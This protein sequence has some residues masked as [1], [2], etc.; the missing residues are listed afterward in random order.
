MIV[1]YRYS[2]EYNAKVPV[3]A[4]CRRRGLSRARRDDDMIDLGRLLAVPPTVLWYILQRLTA[5]A[6]PGNVNGERNRTL[7]QWVLGARLL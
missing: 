5:V 2:V 4:S 1:S 7:K 3:I 6:P